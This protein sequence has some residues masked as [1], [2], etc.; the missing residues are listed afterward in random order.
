MQKLEQTLS[1]KKEAI[2]TPNS[3]GNANNA[4]AKYSTKVLRKINNA[5]TT[6]KAYI[7]ESKA[8]Q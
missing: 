7:G 4:S 8:K 2:F 3:N 1:L 5:S 6:R